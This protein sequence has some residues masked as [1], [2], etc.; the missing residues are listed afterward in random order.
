LILSIITVVKNDYQRLIKTVDS[1]SIYYGDLNFEHII[2]DGRSTDQTLDLIHKLSSKKNIRIL[3]EP[4]SGI[5][6]AMNKGINLSSGKYL[7][8]LNAGDCM[9][10]NNTKLA[11]WLNAVPKNIDIICFPVLMR[12]GDKLLPLMPSSFPRHKM[13]TSHQG[14]IFLREFSISNLYSTK[15]RVAGD[16]DVYLRVN[17]NNLLIYR[18]T[19]YLTEIEYEGYASENP[20]LAYKEYLNIVYRRLKGISRFLSLSRI[21]IW[22]L[23]AISL[24]QLLSKKVISMLRNIA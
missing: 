24:K 15:Y 10:E 9:L 12:D 5:Y 17:K 6:D 22:A 11:S 19:N 1:L 8:F 13:P 16:F 14:M 4:D 20:I 2:I 18:D 23:I 7:L 3:S 21:F